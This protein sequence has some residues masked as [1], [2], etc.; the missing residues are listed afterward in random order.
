VIFFPGESDIHLKNILSQ[1]HEDFLG[2]FKMLWHL[3]LGGFIV[4]A[5]I[6]LPLGLIIYH[7]S[8]PYLKKHKLRMA[9]VV[10]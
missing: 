1:Y 6:A 7:K 3:N 2:T 5:I 9:R 10:A 8:Q 4:W